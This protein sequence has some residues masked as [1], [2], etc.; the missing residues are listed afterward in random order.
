MYT[1]SAI[2]TCK[3][4]PTG[5]YPGNLFGFVLVMLFACDVQCQNK[6]FMLFLKV[7]VIYGKYYAI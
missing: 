5:Q 7:H 1:V 4:G 2:G 6:L 3:G